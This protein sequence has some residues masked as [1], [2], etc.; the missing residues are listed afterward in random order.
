[1]VF[2]APVLFAQLNPGVTETDYANI[3]NAV[4]TIFGI[5][6]YEVGDLINIDSAAGK[7][8]ITAKGVEDPYH[9]LEHCYIF[10]TE[11][12]YQDDGFYRPK[13]FI[14]IFKDGGILW[15]SDSVVTSGLL[16]CGFFD[17]SDINHDGK[18]EFS[19]SWCEGNRSQFRYLWIFSWDGSTGDLLNDINANRRS[20]ICYAEE[21]LN[22]VDI[23]GDGIKELQGEVED[24]TEEGTH[25]VVYSWSGLKYGNYA[26]SPPPSGPLNPRNNV[27]VDVKA[28]T[29]KFK[30]RK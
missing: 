9:T 1:M 8:W 3:Q 30:P 6:K 23:N 13:G 21:S 26:V 24:D 16:S 2:M 14:G 11:G 17:I 19:S 7:K 15:R 4:N 5:N 10:D 20:I 18:V 27:N 29:K 28:N 12:K 25:T 22:I